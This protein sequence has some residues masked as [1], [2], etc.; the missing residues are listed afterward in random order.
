MRLLPRLV[1][2]QLGARTR[3]QE[4]GLW[5]VTPQHCC[6]STLPTTGSRRLAR[7]V[8]LQLLAQHAAREREGGRQRGPRQP[9][10]TAATDF[11]A[12]LLLLVLRHTVGAAAAAA[13]CCCCCC[14]LLLLLSA[15]AA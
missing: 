13:V 6:S 14:L 12:Q 1:V 9:T 11:T 7:S 15:A 8:E 5:A 4:E 3:K 2:N 10:P